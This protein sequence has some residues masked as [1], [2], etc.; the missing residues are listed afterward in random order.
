MHF[1]IDG[2][3]LL[4][5]MGLM[6][7][8]LGPD[9]L[10]RARRALLGRLA[11]ALS[12]E[13]HEVTVVFDAA[14]APPDVPDEERHRGIRVLYSQ[15]KGEE[16]DDVIERLIQ[17]DSAPKRLTVV[18]NDQRLVRAAKRRS[19][20]AMDGSR[21]LDWLDR[22]YASK[23][24]EKPNA[25]PREKDRGAGPSEAAHWLREFAELDQD[26]TLGEPP[27]LQE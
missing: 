22:Q 9:G 26:P 7:P 19:A 1:L 2:Y 3:N 8:R 5:V 16:A 25:E 21:F 4:H 17:H 24:P 13:E 14:E 23:Q 18:S 20:L 15:R 12:A 11:G 6:R 27:R 10:L